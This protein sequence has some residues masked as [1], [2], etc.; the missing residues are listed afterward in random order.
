[1]TRWLVGTIS[2]ASATVAPSVSGSRSTLPCGASCRDSRYTAS[3]PSTAYGQL[4]EMSANLPPRSVGV[5]ASHEGLPLTPVTLLH[6]VHQPAAVRG[7]RQEVLRDDLVGDAVGEVQPVGCATELAEPH[8]LPEPC[9]IGDEGVPEPGSVV[10]PGHRAAHQMDVWDGFVDDLATLDVEDVQ[11]PVLGPVLR[12]RD[13]EPAAVRRRDEPVDRGLAR[14]IDRLRVHDDALGPGVVQVGERHQERP[15]T[16]R[17]LL[18]REVG[19][20]ARRQA[21]VRR[22][23]GP[24]Q[25]LDARSQ[26]VAPRQGRRSTR[27]S[28][29][30]APSS[31]RWS[32]RRTRPPAIDSPR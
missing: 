23:L 9:G 11:R 12:Q 10:A 8:L 18:Q 2:S 16:R 3:A 4:S 31:R 1:M 13:G 24:Q 6:P 25:L 7:R 26:R 17:L 29:P 14:R 20:P 15:L 21:R 5:L 30:A 27:A 22:P 19:A 32:P 28:A